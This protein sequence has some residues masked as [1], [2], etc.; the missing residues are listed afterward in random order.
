MCVKAFPWE[1]CKSVDEARNFCVGREYG[2][3]IRHAL[4][5]PSSV[6]PPTSIA[7]FDFLW[8]RLPLCFAFSEI[9]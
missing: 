8:R 6:G 3:R 2:T 4:H 7:R 1:I 9:E 5:G